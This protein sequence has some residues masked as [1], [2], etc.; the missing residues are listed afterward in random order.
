[1][2]T[3]KGT[4]SK[5]PQTATF[6][7]A[8]G[9]I[10]MMRR[11]RDARLS[12]KILISFT[13]ASLVPLYAL[14]FLNDQANSDILRRQQLDNLTPRSSSLA[15]QI[16][17][18]LQTWSDNAA[19]LA[20]EPAV[21]AYLSGNV[22]V[23]P[24]E[25]LLRERVADSSARVAFLASADGRVTASTDPAL[26]GTN[27]FKDIEFFQQAAKGNKAISDLSVGRLAPLPAIY[28]ASPVRDALGN[29][30]GVAALREDPGK[31]IGFIDAKLL[32]QERYAMIL[33]QN[34][35]VIGTSGPQSILYHSIGALN[36][37][38]QAR[39]MKNHTFGDTPVPS[40]GMTGLADDIV[41]AT[42]P[43]N[44]K[45]LFRPTHQQQVFGFAPMKAERWE[46]VVAQPESA[47]LA[48][49]DQSRNNTIVFTT[50][51]AA[52]FVFI[53]FAVARLFERAERQSYTDALTGL[54]N[55]RYFHEILAREMVRSDRTH[56]P[57][58]LINVD[59][60]HFKTVNDEYGHAKGDEILRGF[61]KV[62]K[63]Q[64][65]SIDLPARYGGE[66][67]LILL[68]DTDKEGAVMVAEKIRRA[69]DRVSIPRLGSMPGRRLSS[70]AGV[71]TSPTDT[72]DLEELV[73]CSDQAMYLAKNLGR[74]QVVGYGMDTSITSLTGHP[75][76]VQVLV[77]NANK[78]TIEALAAAIDARDTYTH[79]HSHR[80]ADYA[81]IVA[82]ELEEQVIDLE[83]LY[84][85]ALLHDVGKIGISD[86]L[87]RKPSRLTADEYETI[88]SHVQIGYEMVQGV[89]FLKNV[90]PIIL[91]SHEN[92]DGT[93]YP[94]GTRGK[95]IPVEARI[96]M[97]CDTFDAMTSTRTYRKAGPVEEA[98][99]EIQRHAGRQF[100]PDIVEALKRAI[101]KGKLRLVSEPPKTAAQLEA[102]EEAEAAAS[103]SA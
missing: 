70:S 4:P 49:V 78:A 13:V 38:E 30:V 50:L 15:V 24:N 8:R 82:T 94:R 53:L 96:I 67:F 39:I 77:Q 79:G 28:F 6:P 80:V 59:L 95:A 72:M 66:E 88:K 54:P 37:T 56:R 68:P 86:T 63:E 7:L 87:L 14:L 18:Q 16:D 84:L 73:R 42:S 41:G 51:V 81:R 58:S 32:G 102:I 91:N 65:R 64:V 29:V 100:D 47:F 97:V 52:V 21:I 55:R 3:T 34:G 2:T 101:L 26:Y 76:R 40:L 25:P 45:A 5:R 83:A 98:L 69:T 71:A 92:Y 43:G 35:V 75:E 12:T 48:P 31:L 93:G 44:I 57:L 20:L 19:R 11:V 62:L 89:D 36:S 46:I 23:N 74:N 61:A 17:D 22:A 9:R 103:T 99:T 85:A 10:E 60:D 90:G 27:E 1:M 33:D